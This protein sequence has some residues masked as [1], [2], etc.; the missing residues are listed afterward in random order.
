MGALLFQASLVLF[1][2]LLIP[3]TALAQESDD[4]YIRRLRGKRSSG[5][6]TTVSPAKSTETPP[7]TDS[8]DD[9]IKRLRKKPGDGDTAVEP[10][11]PSADGDDYAEKLRRKREQ[12]QKEE[13]DE[14]LSEA[15]GA[16]AGSLDAAERK[17]KDALTLVES[18]KRRCR[19]RKMRLRN[20]L[21]DVEEQKEAVRQAFA[22]LQQAVAGQDRA[23]LGEACS[24]GWL[25]SRAG[26]PAARG[27]ANGEFVLSTSGCGLFRS[28][29]VNKVYVYGDKEAVA[30]IA[31]DPAVTRLHFELT[32]ERWRVV[33]SREWDVAELL[34]NAALL[35]AAFTD[36][37]APD[38][39]AAT[40]P[41]LQHAVGQQRSALKSSQPGLLLD[42]VSTFDMAVLNGL[43]GADIAAGDILLD[44]L[45]SPES[46]AYLSGLAV[47]SVGTRLEELACTR[48]A[49]GGKG[50]GMASLYWHKEED[51]WRLVYV[52]PRALVVP[53]DSDA[54]AVRAVMG[55]FSGGI[56]D[57]ETIAEIVALERAAVMAGRAYREWLAG[58]ALG[59]IVIQHPWAR[60]DARDRDGSTHAFGLVE[61]NGV[62]RIAAVGPDQ[63]KRLPDLSTQ[64]STVPLPKKFPISTPFRRALAAMKGATGSATDEL[65]ADACSRW[66]VSP[67]QAGLPARLAAMLTPFCTE[68]VPRWSSTPALTVTIQGAEAVIDLGGPAGVGAAEK[69]SFVLDGEAWRLRGLW[70]AAEARFYAHLREKDASLAEQMDSGYRMRTLLG[71]PGHEAGMKA[72]QE[73]VSTPDG[74]EV[75]RLQ[76]TIAQHP[77]SDFCRILLA[78]AQLAAGQAQDAADVCVG[79]L[80]VLPDS[81]PALTGLADAFATAGQFAEAAALYED[82]CETDGANPF[83]RFRTALMHC[84]SGNRPAAS[85][86]FG[87]LARLAPK[88]PWGELAQAYLALGGKQPGEGVQILSRLASNNPAAQRDIQELAEACVRGKDTERSQRLMAAIPQPE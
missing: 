71:M 62:W 57:A 10:A 27:Q 31:G 28:L 46:V 36:M 15:D 39:D 52:T 40:V 49:P 23:A 58:L 47:S 69:L 70:D 87:R 80:A 44:G 74:G 3:R 21:F 65:V 34:R 26:I 59:D 4:D 11:P 78:R 86:S 84:A 35:E 18:A 29:S 54:I 83:L 82:A 76:L 25:R 20:E 61:H 88:S 16:T 8:D 5:S 45:V 14:A 64:S 37:A 48:L 85:A 41:A 9:Y 73:M 19:G 7:A 1:C 33:D 22:A 38:P 17:L 53:P 55:R 72:L 13:L 12:R 50:M 24:V 6:E 43:D 77:G 42:C 79:V 30:L 66:F 67:E 56:W 32:G 60:I 75:E 81:V 68:S 63:A 51:S 2:M